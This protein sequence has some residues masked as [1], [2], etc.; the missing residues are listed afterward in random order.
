VLAKAVDGLREAMDQG[1]F[2]N[3]PACENALA[4]Y[5]YSCSS[6]LFFIN[7]EFKITGDSA[8]R[9]ARSDLLEAYKEFSLMHKLQLESRNLLYEL[10]ITLG[11]GK[12]TH[13]SAL[14]LS[15]GEDRGFTGLVRKSD[16]GAVDS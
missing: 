9:I 2:D 3:P 11:E 7:S 16:D 10:L 12:I 13:H 8:D 15:G 1:D 6:A 5:K 4:E 14:K